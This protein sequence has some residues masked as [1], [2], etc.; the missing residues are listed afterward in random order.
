MVASVVVA[1]VVTAE[2]RVVR[3]D[4]EAVVA[5]DVEAVV[6]VAARVAVVA[7]VEASAELE[8]VDGT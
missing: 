5:V 1:S 8:A 3:L 4:V 6:A 2:T 7:V